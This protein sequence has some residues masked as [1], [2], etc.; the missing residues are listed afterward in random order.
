MKSI[1]NSIV[2]I[3]STSKR[4][5]ENIYREWDRMRNSATGPNDLAEIDAI[6]HRHLNEKEMV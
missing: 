4:S 1:Y 3:F 5:N 2:N 6:F